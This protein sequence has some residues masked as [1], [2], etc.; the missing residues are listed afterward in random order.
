MFI[1]AL[2]VIPRN[3]KHLRC[4]SVEKGIKKMWYPYTM[5][6]KEAVS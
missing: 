6:Q 4:P 5:V 3:W 1:V 2:F